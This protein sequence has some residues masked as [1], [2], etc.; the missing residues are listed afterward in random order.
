MRSESYTCPFTSGF[1]GVSRDDTCYHGVILGKV[2]C[3]FVINKS[4]K[5]WEYSIVFY[6]VIVTIAC[7]NIGHTTYNK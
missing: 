5:S 3:E 4:Q 6:L 1:V 7:I 2:L